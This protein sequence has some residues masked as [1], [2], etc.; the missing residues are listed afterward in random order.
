MTEGRS[1]LVIDLAEVPFLDSTGLGALT[2]SLKA[3]RL[4]GG[5]LVLSRPREQ[6]KAVLELAALDRVF[7][8]YSTVEEALADS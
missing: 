3:A 5:Y 2:S 6:A 4:L 1:R 8:V 7:K